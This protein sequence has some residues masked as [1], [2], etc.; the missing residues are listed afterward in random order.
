MKRVSINETYFQLS[1]VIATSLFMSYKRMTWFEASLARAPE[2]KTNVAWSYLGSDLIADL[3]TLRYI[4]LYFHR[5]KT[6]KSSAVFPVPLAEPR[7]FHQN[8]SKHFMAARG[9]MA[10][11]SKATRTLIF[12]TF[13]SSISS[14]LPQSWFAVWLPSALAPSSA[15]AP[16]CSPSWRPRE[17]WIRNRTGHPG[18]V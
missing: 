15:S 5:G 10:I 9:D 16:S 7:I 6:R 11:H 12:L 1:F 18:S 3:K 13:S 14:A 2:N 17:S 8:I 4:R